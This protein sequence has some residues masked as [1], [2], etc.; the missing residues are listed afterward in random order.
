MPLIHF[1]VLFVHSFSILFFCGLYWV[2]LAEMD[3]VEE[4]YDELK[5]R[6]IAEFKE[7]LRIAFDCSFI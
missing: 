3:P 7:T 4:K 1:R 2:C 6:R 5:A